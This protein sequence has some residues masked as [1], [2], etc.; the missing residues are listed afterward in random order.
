MTR[1]KGRSGR[2][3]LVV[4][5]LLAAASVYSTADAAGNQAAPLNPAEQAV[6]R[7]ARQAMAQKQYGAAHLLLT[8]FKDRQPQG[9]HCLVTFTLANALALDGDAPTALIHYKAA[10]DDCPDNAEVWHNMG[11]VYY[12]LKHYIEAGDSLL[13]AH[14][15]E[16]P[17]IAG[18]G[19]SGRCG[20]LDGG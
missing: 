11:N 4:F 3:C 9:V 6:V 5:W 1:V 2:H 15:L 13:R 16:K 19:L 7:R 18:H 20:L 17:Q 12:D 8:A 10:A 14:A